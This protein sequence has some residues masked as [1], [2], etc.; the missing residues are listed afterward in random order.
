MKATRASRS[1]KTLSRCFATYPRALPALFLAAVLGAGFAREVLAVAVTGARALLAAAAL[2][3]FGFA[4]DFFAT[5]FLAGLL[6]GL[7]GRFGAFAYASPL[8]GFSSLAGF[9]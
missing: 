4:A 6:A 1:G 9:S 3:D 2:S 7:L 5:A 8:A